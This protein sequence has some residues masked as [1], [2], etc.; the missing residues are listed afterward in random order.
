MNK[1]SRPAAGFTLIEV[2]LALAIF[3]GSVAVLSRLLIVGTEFSEIAE[4]EAQA[5]LLAESRWA[6]L[7]SGIRSLGETGPF[8]VEEYPGWEWGFES[9][10][11]ELPSLY[12]VRLFVRKATNV[13]GDTPSIELTR[14]FFDDS[15]AR[16]Q[17]QGASGS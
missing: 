8:P 9:T 16:Q 5:W 11:T 7:E 13:P 4:F 6:E 12:R 3:V 17:Q 10:A 2:I 1:D 14:F 15:T